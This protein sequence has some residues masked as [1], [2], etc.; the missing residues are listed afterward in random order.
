MNIL[1]TKNAALIQ[2]AFDRNL[3]KRLPVHDAAKCAIIFNAL[4]KVSILACTK[5][6]KG[7]K[8]TDQH[9]K[10]ALASVISLCIIMLNMIDNRN[11]VKLVVASLDTEVGATIVNEEIVEVYE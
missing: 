7:G 2:K 11:K 6:Y 1:T 8:V 5:K 10:N 3:K 4:G 9:I